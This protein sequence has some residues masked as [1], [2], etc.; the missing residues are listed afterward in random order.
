MPSGAASSALRGAG[1]LVSIV[2][3]R[4]DPA[5]A[6]CY[7]RR[8]RVWAQSPSGGQAEVGSAVTIFVNP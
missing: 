4:C 5:D 1:F 6:A 2:E 7:P 8:G 3:E